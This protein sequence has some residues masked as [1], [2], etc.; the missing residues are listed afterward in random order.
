MRVWKYILEMDFKDDGRE[1]M[2]IFKLL[3]LQDSDL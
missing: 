3:G 1:V 2:N